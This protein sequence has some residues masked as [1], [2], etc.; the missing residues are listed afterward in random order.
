MPMCVEAGED[1]IGNKRLIELIDADIQA[2]NR[3]LK[4]M[5]G[6]KN[7]PYFQGG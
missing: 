2:V 3:T 4:S 1:F 6:S 5:S 7:T